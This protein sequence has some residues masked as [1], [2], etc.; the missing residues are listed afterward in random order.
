MNKD[1]CVVV[2]FADSLA[3]PEVCWS[4]VDAGYRVVAFARN[5][6][7]AAIQYSRYVKLMEIPA[8]EVDLARSVRILQENLSL[9]ISR[10]GMKQVVVFPLDDTSLLLCSR[11]ESSPNI[12]LAGPGSA[13]VAIALDKQL[14][15]KIAQ[16][17]GFRV[18]PTWNQ[19]RG[20]DLNGAVIAKPRFA[21]EIAGNSVVRHNYRIFKEYGKRN[22]RMNGE[23]F[24]CLWQPYIRGGGG[25]GIFG[26]AVGEKV[27]VCSAHRRVRMMNPNGSGSSA[28]ESTK[29]ESPQ[30]DYASRFIQ[31]S[32]WNGLFMIELLRDREGKLWFMEFNGRP[33]GSMALARREGFDYPAWAVRQAL[34][35]EPGIQLPQGNQ[36]GIVCRHVGRELLHILFAIRGAVKGKFN[37]WPAISKS[38]AKM[39]TFNRRHHFYNWRDDDRKVFWADIWITF[40]NQFHRN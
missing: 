25:E 32:K 16:S 30:V 40:R 14:Q 15:I 22:A 11:L 39:L 9:L 1:I 33:W 38:L 37:E 31:L 3:A 2:G 26:L 23:E 12:Y 19:N 8:P 5:G 6:T 27:R 10:D 35:G 17:A 13:N 24:E 29:P 7:V 20:G 36:P 34:T 4:L 18:I 21:V 28:C